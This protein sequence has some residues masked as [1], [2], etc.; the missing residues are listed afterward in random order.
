MT[1]G[2][3]LPKTISPAWKTGDG[4][5]SYSV[6][7][8]YAPASEQSAREGVPHGKV[9]TFTMDSASSKFYPGVA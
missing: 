1:F 4:D 6:G 7:P 2:L 9:I 3:S 8:T 5:G